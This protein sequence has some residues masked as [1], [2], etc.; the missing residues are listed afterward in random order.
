ML[1]GLALDPILAVVL[2]VSAAALLWNVFLAG[3]IAQLREAPA[4]FRAVSGLVG[5]LLPP[6][7]FVHV[8]GANILT[9]RAIASVQW[10]W[11]AVLLL[12]VV[13]AAYATGRR[14]VS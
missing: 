8:L 1:P 4:G 6:A 3:Q 13:Q 7:L 9:G 5:L 11:P 10:I 12:F 2:G 14:L